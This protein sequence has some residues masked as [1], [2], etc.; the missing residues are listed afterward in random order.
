M[1][2][3][4]FTLLR[5]K[6]HLCIY[7]NVFYD[8]HF[9]RHSRTTY[10]YIVVPLLEKQTNQGIPFSIFSALIGFIWS[11]QNLDIQ[12]SVHDAFLE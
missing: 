12:F 9:S 10:E 1:Y 2:S 7:D 5:P 11:K 6:R 3:L 8:T 4:Y